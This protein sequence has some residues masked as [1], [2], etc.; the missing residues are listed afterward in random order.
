MPCS[1]GVKFTHK[2]EC[3]RLQYVQMD[4]IQDIYPDRGGCRV[5]KPLTSSCPMVMV[6]A[7]ETLTDSRWNENGSILLDM[8]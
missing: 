1:L 5:T 8:R 3:G 6:M 4:R 2:N 7:N